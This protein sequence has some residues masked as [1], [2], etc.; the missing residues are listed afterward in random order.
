MPI[1]ITYKK[2]NSDKL[3]KTFVLFAD[4]G[5]RA[6]ALKKNIFVKQGKLCK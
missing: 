5:F 2:E 4:E 1:E 6:L 3:A